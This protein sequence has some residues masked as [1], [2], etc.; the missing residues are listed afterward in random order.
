VAEVRDTAR[1]V[2]VSLP[3]VLFDSGK[4]TLRPEAREIISRIGGIVLGAGGMRLK[5]DGHTDNQGSAPMNLRLSQDRAATVQNYLVDA[6]VPADWIQTSG[7][8]ETAPVA[9]NATPEGRK[10]NRRVEIV[11]AIPSRSRPAGA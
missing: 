1:G 7:F 4:A 5:V 8:G 10:Q 6:A 11:I 3:D 2:V 9:D